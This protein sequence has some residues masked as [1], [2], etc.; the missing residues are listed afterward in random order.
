[1]TSF[2]YWQCQQSV[3]S[4]FKLLNFKSSN[5][6]GCKV[7]LSLPNLSISKLAGVRLVTSSQAPGPG[8]QIRPASSC[9]LLK[10]AKS[11][12]HMCKDTQDT[13]THRQTHKGER[14]EHLASLTNICHVKHTHTHTY[15]YR[16][17]PSGSSEIGSVA[18]EG[19]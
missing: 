1:V 16:H 8:S 3:T 10:R 7:C 5:L 17:S 9:N 6:Y 13:H 19:C 4:V 15:I 2:Q 11:W 18:K 12:S 14:F